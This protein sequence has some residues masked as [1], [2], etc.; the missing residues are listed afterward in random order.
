MGSAFL[1]K[2]REGLVGRAGTADPELLSLAL[3]AATVTE[4]SVHSD[5]AQWISLF[6]SEERPNISRTT[7]CSRGPDCRRSRVGGS[8]DTSGEHICA[9]CASEHGRRRLHADIA[10]PGEHFSR[11]GLGSAAA[12]FTIPLVSIEQNRKENSLCL[13]RVAKGPVEWSELRNPGSRGSGTS[14]V[15]STFNRMWRML[16][17]G[18]TTEAHV[19]LS[20]PHAKGNIASA[21][22]PIGVTSGIR[23]T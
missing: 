11:S 8:R 12:V 3:S 17:D 14:G 22:K 7:L 20:R 16:R 1:A 10:F 21:C 4:P 6:P 2:I 19:S 13:R 5:R 15:N 23:Y 9:T 18:I